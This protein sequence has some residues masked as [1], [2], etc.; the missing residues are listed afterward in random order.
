MILVSVMRDSASYVDRYMEQV[1]ALRK[2][3]GDVKV[4]IAEGTRRTTR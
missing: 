1:L 2:L 4:V 3:V